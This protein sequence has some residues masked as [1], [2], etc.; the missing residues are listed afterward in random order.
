MTQEQLINEYQIAQERVSNTIA[1]QKIRMALNMQNHKTTYVKRN[2][3][4][5][6]T[7]LFWFYITGLVMAAVLVGFLG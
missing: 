4:N 1:H 3:G 5:I 7:F 6:R 2:N